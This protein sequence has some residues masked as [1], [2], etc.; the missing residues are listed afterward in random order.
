[1]ISSAAAETLW[2]LWQGGQVARDLPAEFKPVTEDDGYRIQAELDQLSGHTRVGWKIAATS[3]AGQKHIA[4][5]GPIVGRIF[6]AR[7]LAPG[8]TT[9]IETNRM[10]V[11]EPEFAFRFGVDVKPRE[12]P[13]T[14]DEALQAV[15]ALHLAFELPDS[16]FEPFA[17]A[18]GPSLIA[19]NACAHELM[20]GPPVAFDWRTLDL[21][22]H[23][24][25]ACINN[26]T[27]REGSGANVLGDPR[28]ALTWFVNAFS[29]RGE[30]IAAG[31]FVTTGT[32][33][34][35]LDVVEGD[36]V[37]A[38][39]GVLGALKVHIAAK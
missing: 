15:S 38:D 32:C 7:L 13:Y 23:T 11:V 6:A 19:D 37:S 22:R 16:R 26:R 12:R 36:T 20:L 34:A 28:V 31:E 9:S 35:P 25:S 18:G 21:A 5:D 3:L 30:T 10:R 2:Q 33:M 4:V 8:A 39:F 29:R 14:Q 1:M 27:P 24:V 17:A